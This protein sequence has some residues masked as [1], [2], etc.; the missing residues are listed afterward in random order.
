MALF[1]AGVA[2]GTARAQPGA[3]PTVEDVAAV[4]ASS[5]DDEDLYRIA[6]LARQ[7]S[8]QG[9]LQE[10]IDWLNHLK[11]RYGSPDM[12]SPALDPSAW[13]AMLVL[14]QVGMQPDSLV[15]PLGPDLD[16][17]LRVV[18]NRSD[19]RLAWAMLPELLRT[20]PKFDLD[21]RTLAVALLGEFD[22]AAGKKLLQK[23]SRTDPAWQVRRLARAALAL[24]R[25]RSWPPRVKMP[26]GARDYVAYLGEHP[27]H[28]RLILW[29]TSRRGTPE[30]RELAPSNLEIRDRMRT[31]FEE[32]IA[33]GEIKPI[34]L[35]TYMQVLY[36]GY[37]AAIVWKAFPFDEKE[38]PDSPTPAVL[39]G[40]EISR[41]QEQADELVLR[42]LAP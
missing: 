5:E 23:I 31:A 8:G 24:R 32:A 38:A 35:Q 1:V 16:A 34:A 25:G 14:G 12:R 40:E 21:G 41:L 4:M 18:F 19:E 36:V 2:S 9:A 29:E 7:L 20:T 37:A 15:S 3:L 11:S 28:A 42:L 30:W 39:D 10:D 33:R 6:A 27:A 26:G 13:R 22:D 17:Y